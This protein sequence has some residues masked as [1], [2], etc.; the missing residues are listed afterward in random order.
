MNR[1][2]RKDRTVRH[3]DHFGPAFGGPT[4][5][6]PFERSGY[7][8]MGD[9]RGGPFERGGRG[10][11]GRKRGDIRT[12]LLL[13]LAESP[14][15][16]YELI[17]RIE[18][19]SGGRWRPSAGSVYPTLQLLEDEGL[20]TGAEQDGKRVYAITEAGQ[21]QATERADAAGGAPW[22]RDG[23]GDESTDALRTTMRDLHLA[24]T[25]VA[26]AGNPAQVQKATE[27]LADTRK[28][29]YLLLGEE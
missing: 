8:P 3:R 22:A 19:K 17:G 28:R 1:S 25:Q 10:R 5:Q 2:I 15:H 27:L 14:A 4:T 12:A 23:R 9:G 29:L 24:A 20:V 7:G 26:V 13:A 16:G 6:D 18:E 11:G 21:A